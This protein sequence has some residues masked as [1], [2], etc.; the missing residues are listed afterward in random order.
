MLVVSEVTVNH[1]YTPTGL[2]KTPK[3]SWVLESTIEKTKQV[4]Y[5]IYVS[6]DEN[7][8]NIIFCKNEESSASL[9]I[10][11]DFEMESL[12]KY[13]VKVRVKGNYG[14][15]TNFFVTNF[16][17]GIINRELFLGNF[18]TDEKE[19]D[20]NSMSGRLLRQTFLIEKEIESAYSVTTSLGVYKF[21][22][23]GDFVGSHILAP[24]WT[25]YN[26]N[27]LYQTN[28]IT[29]FLKKGENVFGAHIGPAW[30]KGKMGFDENIN[31][32]GKHSGFYGLFLINYKDGTKEFLYTDENW[33]GFKST[34]VFSEIYD[35]E[36][37]DATI[38]KNNIWTTDF[39]DEDYNPTKKI[40]FS[41]NNLNSQSGC[42]VKEQECFLP[43]KIIRTPKEE[44][45]LDFG[46]NLTGYL[47]FNLPETKLG[48]TIELK[49]F[50]VLDKEGNVYTENL[51]KAK[52]TIIYKCKD[53]KDV[54]YKPHFTFQ[55][56]RYVEI[57]SFPTEVKKEYFKA[58]A[59]YSDMKKTLKFET[60]NPLINQLHH[61]IEWGLKGNFLDIPTDCPQRDERLGWT[62]DAQ[63]FCQTASYI[64][65][66]Y[67][68]FEKWLTDLKLEQE[69]DGGVPYVI[70][71]IIDKTKDNWKEHGTHSAA[72]W[73]DVAV[74]NPWV[75]YNTYGD[76]DIILNQY[77]SM[78]KWIDFMEDNS[79]SYI[80]SYKKQFG[81]W[82]A[83]DAEVGSYL[84]ATPDELITTAYFA[85][86]T[87]LFAKMAKIIKNEEDYE[88]YSS[89]YEKV[90]YTF[91]KKFFT[92]N[93]EMTTKTQTGH[94]LA[95]KFNLVE[96][97][98]KEQTV[99]NLIE[100]LNKENGH[101]V[102]GF[103]GTPYFCSALSKN[104]KIAEAYNLLL[105]EDFP[106]WLYQVK[107]G[108]TTI[109][110][111]W[112]GINEK[113][114]MWSSDMNSF[115]HYAYGAIGQWMYEDMLGLN[116]DEENPGFKH[117]YIKPNA[118]TL[119]SKV[120]GK[121]KS[122]YGLIKIK[123]KT[124]GNNVTLK[125]TIPPN[126]SGTVIVNNSEKTY[127]SGTYE[128]NYTI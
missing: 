32:Y 63:I 62:G 5:E 34:V 84:G 77:D 123:W 108:A 92:E 43:K 79:T 86:S 113:G 66:T 72:A 106:S 85:Y 58:I 1:L 117:F 93:G 56:F 109:W 14:N 54:K 69:E 22:I 82:V 105:K 100:L 44:I 39:N 74:I 70:P 26:K 114:E 53:K 9:L 33:K 30:Y 102:T 7:F 124:K 118:T 125:F 28:E 103:V 120:K 80:W 91:R 101:L 111:H 65:D 68:F 46:Q 112:D 64:M 50:E 73:S 13:Y 2:T 122:P 126:T 45:V 76:I 15:K 89:L 10:P 128:I 78:K 18:I 71:D 20:Y 12:K 6:P 83:L 51:R 27:L 61:N 127:E 35:G 49:F 99:N 38:E 23:N 36:I 42:Y 104:G 4:S 55:G 11:L 24:G 107:M 67:T 90:L 60:S 17:T 81:D 8:E 41:F 75:L 52:Q 16:T 98:Y 59:L 21:R 110:E 47:E 25:S 48:E 31:N 115:N 37:Y 94:I 116:F 40:D 87:E 119:F 3:I 121:F 97:K 95:L 88:Y 19:E 29:S 96:D 57:V